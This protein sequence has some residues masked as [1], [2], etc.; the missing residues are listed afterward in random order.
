VFEFLK[1]WVAPPPPA[2]SRRKRKSTRAKDGAFSGPLPL[3][4]PAPEVIEGNEE[5][6]WALWEDSVSVL[7]SRSQPLSPRDS[8]YDRLP[9]SSQF[10]DVDAFSGVR[11][12]DK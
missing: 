5:T 4:A 10:S 3:A 12:R 7:D 1:R 9:S 11:K 6:D 8:V 2:P